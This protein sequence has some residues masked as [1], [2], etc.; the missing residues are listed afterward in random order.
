M[1][2]LFFEKFG[3]FIG[4]LAHAK[5]LLLCTVC[6]KMM[7]GLYFSS[8]PKVASSTAF[9]ISENGTTIFFLVLRTKP[10]E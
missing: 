8:A 6:L 3:G 5:F 1:Y 7:Y 2:L 9:F 4:T 10:V